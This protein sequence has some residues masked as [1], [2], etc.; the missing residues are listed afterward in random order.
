[1]ASLS[2]S[3]SCEQALNSALYLRAQPLQA[4]LA[5]RM[6]LGM[7][8]GFGCLSGHTQWVYKMFP[9]GSSKFSSPQALLTD[10]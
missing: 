7:D 1:M 4:A 8:A 10:G 3:Y 9:V 6:A 5:S 2:M